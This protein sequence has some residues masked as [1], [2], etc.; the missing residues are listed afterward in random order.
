[1]NVINE[2]DETMLEHQK[3]RAKILDQVLAKGANKA[4]VLKFVK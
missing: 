1:M 3:M 4:L 2:P